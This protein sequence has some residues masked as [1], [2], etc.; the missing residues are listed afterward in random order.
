MGARGGLDVVAEEGVVFGAD[1]GDA[2]GE[3]EEVGS[4]GEGPGCG[5]SCGGG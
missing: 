1:D 2:G 3:E 4:E 5:C